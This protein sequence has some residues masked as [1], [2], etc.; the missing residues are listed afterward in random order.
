[1]VKIKDKTGEESYNNFGSKMVVLKY[2]NYGNIDVYFP[3]YD[4]ISYNKHYGDFKKG[5]I[6]CPFEPRVYG[7]GY[8]GIGK[9]TIHDENKKMTK[10]YQT[11]HGMLRR[12]YSDSWK[13]SN[14]TYNNC[15]V[16]SEWLNFQNFA[17]WFY[18]NYYEID[19][20]IMNLDKDILYKYNNEYGPETCIYAPHRI[21]NLFIRRESMRGNLPIGVKKY[22]NK[23]EAG[24]SDEQ[25]NRVV[26]GIFN[27]PEEAFY[28][29]K[30]YKEKLIKDIADNYKDFIP[31]KLYEAMYNYEVEI[32]D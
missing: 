26:L 4:Y 5:K 22:G 27:T 1:M 17:E 9:Y 19:G 25:S 23:F 12:C 3:E 29:Y 21:N 24:Y 20:E 18:L 14:P 31:E 11:W 7:I 13:S 28:V 2:T 6:S 10:A 8:T 16:C 30:E 32:D 15:H